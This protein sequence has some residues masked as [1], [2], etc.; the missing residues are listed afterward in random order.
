[1]NTK[2]TAYH[3]AGHAVATWRLLNKVPRRAT[4]IP[5]PKKNTLGHILHDSP[6]KGIRLD[7]D[8]SLRA[9]AR[10]H[11][12]IM[13][14]LAGAIAQ[15]RIAPRSVRSWHPR[16]DY[17]RAAEIAHRLCGSDKEVNACLRWLQVRTENLIE[18]DWREVEAVAKALIER[19]TLNAEEI[20]AAIR[21][22]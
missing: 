18:T 16:S 4:V 9:E 8:G 20:W 6:L 12:V 14:C 11:Q 17:E 21:E 10:A 3:E 22:A 7:I 15:R 19:S 1:M 5:N 13:I 2:A